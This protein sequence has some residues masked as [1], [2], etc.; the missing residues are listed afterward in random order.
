MCSSR[1][2][3]SDT[4]RCF[5]GPADYIPLLRMI[6]NLPTQR[7]FPYPAARFIS[8]I[9]AKP[10][11]RIGNYPHTTCI[12]P[13][14]EKPRIR[15]YNCS[16]V[17]GQADSKYFQR[18][19]LGKAGG[20]NQNRRDEICSALFLHSARNHHKTEAEL[21]FPLNVTGAESAS[22]DHQVRPIM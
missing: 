19:S 14:P 15:E 21:Q 17:F 7:I 13:V 6:D 11:I 3:L 18:S 9:E 8:S 16:P 2:V 10:S 5:A 12:A 1:W 20:F 4:C 22:L